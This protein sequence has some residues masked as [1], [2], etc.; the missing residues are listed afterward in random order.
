MRCIDKKKC[1]V[2]IHIFH[3]LNQHIIYFSFQRDFFNKIPKIPYNP[4]EQFYTKLSHRAALNKA[5]LFLPCSEVFCVKSKF[6][7]AILVAI[8]F[9]NVGY[10]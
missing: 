2:L 9:N 6:K 8:T 7:I 5:A 4:R 3:R 10:S 1:L